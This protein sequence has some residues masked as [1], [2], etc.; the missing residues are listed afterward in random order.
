MVRLHP[1]GTEVDVRVVQSSG[2]VQVGSCFLRREVQGRGSE[3]TGT[4]LP[5]GYVHGTQVKQLQR[6]GKERREGRKEEE[7]GRGEGMKEGRGGKRREREEGEGKR[8][9]REG[10]RKE[11]REST[12]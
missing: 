1:Q 10:G 6:G 9:G 4:E 11:S 8:R 2:Q 12:C 5:K 7:G 3:D